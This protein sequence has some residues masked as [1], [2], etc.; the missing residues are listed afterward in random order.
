MTLVP[1]TDDPKEA[2]ESGVSK[3]IETPKAEETPEDTSEEPPAP[4]HSLDSEPPKPS[5][6]RKSKE[7]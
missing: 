5:R 3:F 6:S 7:D 2:K 4:A 1:A